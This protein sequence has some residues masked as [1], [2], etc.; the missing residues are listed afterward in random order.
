[1]FNV[2]DS[3]YGGALLDKATVTRL[4]KNFPALYGTRRFFAAFITASHW[5]LFSDRLIY[6]TR[7]HLLLDP[8][9]HVFIS[10]FP[11]EAL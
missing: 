10:G 1:M 8:P 4:V 9:S 3:L 7:S 6:L 2:I 11:T 5:S